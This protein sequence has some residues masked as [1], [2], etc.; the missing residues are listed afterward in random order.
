MTLRVRLSRDDATLI[1]LSDAPNRFGVMPLEVHVTKTSADDAVANQTAVVIRA[2]KAG[3]YSTSLSDSRTVHSTIS[4]VPAALDLTNAPWHLAA[5][6]WQ[7]ANTYAT[8]FGA[9]AT[10]TRKTP[11]VLELNSLKPWPEIPALQNSSGI[12]AYS[13]TFDLPPDGPA[14]M[15]HG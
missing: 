13:T 7:P 8:T 4:H 5:E 15:A 11:V 3:T 9:A 12:G 14:R 10:E 2:T 1:A 6:D